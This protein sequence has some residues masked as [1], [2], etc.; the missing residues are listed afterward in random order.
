MENFPASG[1]T[2]GEYGFRA[3]VEAVLGLMIQGKEVSKEN[4]H[5]W[6][7]TTTDP[8]PTREVQG[9]ATHFAERMIN[10]PLRPDGS[11]PEIPP[12]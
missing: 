12:L 4:V 6:V 7:M 8:I 5:A 3:A 10:G 1:G 11:A 9:R 2:T